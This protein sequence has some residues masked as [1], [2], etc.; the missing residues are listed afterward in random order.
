MKGA[1]I[2]QRFFSWFYG[3]DGKKKKKNKKKKKQDSNRETKVFCF[4][5]WDED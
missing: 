2:S 3:D 5:D 4:V 1:A